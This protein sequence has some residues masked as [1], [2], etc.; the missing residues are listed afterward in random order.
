MGR[1]RHRVFVYGTLT[2]PARAERVLDDWRFDGAAA[3]VGLHRVDGRY[4]TLA[5]GGRTAGRLLVTPE[6]RALDTYEGVD[7]GLYVRVA[8]PLVADDDR[9]EAGAAAE[10][11]WVYVGDPE[12]LDAGVEWPGSGPLDGRVERYVAAEGVRVRRAGNR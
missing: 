9:D 6:L 1:E 11:A 7:R 3:L 8:V 2:D 4:P 12:R 5:P 10:E